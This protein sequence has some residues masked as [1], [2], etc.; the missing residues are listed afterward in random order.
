MNH[1][2]TMNTK[3]ELIDANGQWVATLSDD[4]N[5][6]DFLAGFRAGHGPVNGAI[7]READ[8]FAW[9]AATV[10]R[11]QEAARAARRAVMAF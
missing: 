4:S 9:E 7:I 5:I 6:L 10:T 8:I 2:L 3:G 11:R 1:L